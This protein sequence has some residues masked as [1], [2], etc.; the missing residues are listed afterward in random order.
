MHLIEISS[1]QATE[2][3]CPV[4][5]VSLDHDHVTVDHVEALRKLLFAVQESLDS[6]ADYLFAAGEWAE[7]ESST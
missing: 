2:S 5:R 4:C 6:V 1:S 3:H 7:E